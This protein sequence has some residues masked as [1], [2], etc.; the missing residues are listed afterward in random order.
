MAS[1]WANARN[2]EEGE[3]TEKERIQKYCSSKTADRN[4]KIIHVVVLG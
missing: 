4:G 1:N 2:G 3:K